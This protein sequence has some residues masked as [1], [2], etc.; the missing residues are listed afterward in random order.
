MLNRRGPTPACHGFP[1]PRLA[2][3]SAALFGFLIALAGC[4][5]GTKTLAEVDPRAAAAFPGFEEVR[6]ILNR[7]CV[8]CHKSGKPAAEPLES[9]ASYRT[10]AAAGVS[11]GGT[12]TDPDFDTCEGIQAGFGVLLRVIEEDTMPPGS[13]PRLEEWEKQVLRNWF[14]NSGGCSPC[15]EECP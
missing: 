15:T 4:N 13:W 2:L 1:A 3:L 8:P 10:L 12:L 14:F 6:A 5:S 7:E 9:A 11:G